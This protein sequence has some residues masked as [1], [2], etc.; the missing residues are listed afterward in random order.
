MGN[1]KFFTPKDQSIEVQ[2]LDGTW[3]GLTLGAITEEKMTAYNEIA[4]IINADNSIECLRKEAA[5]FYG[6]NEEDYKD[7]DIRVLKGI[8]DFV[9]DEI[10]NQK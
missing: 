4:K 6:G 3:T 10:R 7:Y 1:K 9:T 5:L 8:I 2:K